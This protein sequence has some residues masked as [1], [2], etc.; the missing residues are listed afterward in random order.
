MHCIIG[1]VEH[2]QRFCVCDRDGCSLQIARKCEEV[3]HSSVCDTSNAITVAVYSRD[4]RESNVV[5]GKDARMRLS[6][7]AACLKAM[8]CTGTVA[9]CSGWAVVAGGSYSVY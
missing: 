4:S 7:P 5:L 2:G 9:L 3:V 6:C 8:Y 1:C